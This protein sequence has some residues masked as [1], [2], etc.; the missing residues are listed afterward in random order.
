MM[1]TTYLT[2]RQMILKTGWSADPQQRMIQK[3]MLYG[4]PFSLLMSGWYFP[5]GVIVYWVTQNLFSLGQQYWVLHKYPPPVVAGSTPLKDTAKDT[6]VAKGLFARFLPQRPAAAAG[7]GF[8][9]PA[10]RRLGLFRRRPD[11]AP[12]PPVAPR[13]LA[14]KPGAKPVVGKQPSTDS[15]P[16]PGQSKSTKD[17]VTTGAAA[18]TGT[19]ASHAA[20]P[21][22]AAPSAA[23]PDAAAPSAAAPDAAATSA[24][25]PNG[26]APKQN[27]QPANKSGRT[28]STGNPAGARKKTTTVRKGSTRK[29]GGSRR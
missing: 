17:S 25:A 11:A 22:A 12:T 21:S 4:I 7:N 20:A 13:S 2:S 9:N 10:Q 27:P 18:G 29:K 26:A 14:P 6:A 1:V 5:I 24:A 15:A 28:A 16:G 19:A 23:A 3:L 8:V